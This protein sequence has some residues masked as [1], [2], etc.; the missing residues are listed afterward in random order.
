MAAG[1]QDPGVNILERFL[2]TF[3][4]I[5]PNKIIY[6]LSLLYPNQTAGLNTLKM[7]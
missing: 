3:E 4:P 7:C 1:I 2:P 6:N 5:R